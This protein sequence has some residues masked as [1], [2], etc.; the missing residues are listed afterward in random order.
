MADKNTIKVVADIE[1]SRVVAGENGNPPTVE[2]R[3][4]TVSAV[5]TE[6]IGL[7]LTRVDGV[8]DISGYVELEA[9]ILR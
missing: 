7:E 2:T 5:L 3:Q 6:G 1:D 9:K 8:A 4:L